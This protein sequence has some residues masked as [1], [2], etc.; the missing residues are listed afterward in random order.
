MQSI[1]FDRNY[2]CSHLPT[3]CWTTKLRPAKYPWQPVDVRVFSVHSA[4]PL[5]G[6]L[7][8]LGCA[9]PTSAVWA[10]KLV[11]PISGMSKFRLL[12][13][14]RARQ[15]P[16]YARALRRIIVATT[17]KAK[18]WPRTSPGAFKLFYE[19]G[20]KLNALDRCPTATLRLWKPFNLTLRRYHMP[21]VFWRFVDRRSEAIVLRMK[22]LEA[23]TLTS[24][25]IKIAI[26]PPRGG[27]SRTDIAFVAL[28]L[29]GW[30]FSN[31]RPSSTDGRFLY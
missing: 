4:W 17:D 3:L 10:R 24:M 2:F 12:Q 9:S 8:A 20:Y 31:P 29:I 16:S 1:A 18:T 13:A 27:I 6:L 23:L 14:V 30:N 19:V 11:R 5:T 22:H 25:L 28:I 26:R 21:Y 7:A 15:I